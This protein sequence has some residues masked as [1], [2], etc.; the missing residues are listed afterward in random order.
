MSKD[1]IHDLSKFKKEQQQGQQPQQPQITKEDVMDAPDVGCSRC[2]GELFL[3]ATR[4]K[5]LSKLLTGES[6][7]R[8]VNLQT[9]VCAACGL[10]FGKDPNVDAQNEDVGQDSPKTTFDE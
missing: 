9:M 6:E 2:G 8:L 5:R 7:D 3:P 1:N 10:E 4:F